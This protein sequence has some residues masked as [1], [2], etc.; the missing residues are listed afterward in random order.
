MVGQSDSL[1]DKLVQQLRDES[2]VA[3]R[4][5][6]GALRLHGERAVCAISQLSE[7]LADKD[8][9]VRAEASNA[10]KILRRAAA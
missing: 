10:L 3:R 7:L 8:A 9:R 2:P 6:A 4:N 1:I 5:A